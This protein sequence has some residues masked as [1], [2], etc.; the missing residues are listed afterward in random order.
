MALKSKFVIH[1]DNRDLWIL[2]NFKATHRGS[3]S[4]VHK[5]KAHSGTNSATQEPCLMKG[6]SMAD[7]LAKKAARNFLDVYQNL[8]L[9][10]LQ[11]AI[12]LQTHLV[13]TLAERT[14]HFKSVSVQAPHGLDLFP[15]ISFWRRSLFVVAVRSSGC[16]LNPTFAPGCARV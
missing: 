2:F 5:V 16:A 6:N 11:S 8:A 12:S 9:E 4:S 1:L 7:D 13:H 14:A 10:E 3:S 15:I